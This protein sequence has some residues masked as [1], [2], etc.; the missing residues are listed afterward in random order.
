MY[1]RKWNGSEWE[2]STAK[3]WDGSNWVN[4][5]I[6]TW[7]GSEWVYPR[8]S[9][10]YGKGDTPVLKTYTK[11]YYAKWAHTYNGDNRKYTY[12]NGLLMQGYYINENMKSLFGF[13]FEEIQRDLRGATINNVGLYLTPATFMVE[14]LTARVH[15]H[16]FT[17]KPEFFDLTIMDVGSR[18]FKRDFTNKM[19]PTRIEIDPKA[20]GGLLTGDVT[21]FGLYDRNSTGKF[22]DVKYGAWY[23]IH[24]NYTYLE[25]SFTK[26][27]RG[28]E[29]EVVLDKKPDYSNY[30]PADSYKYTLPKTPTYNYTPTPTKT[31]PVVKNPVLVE[32]A[33]YFTTPKGWGLSQIVDHL[34]REGIYPGKNDA[35]WQASRAKIMAMNNFSST[36]P[37]LQIGQKVKYQ[38][39]KYK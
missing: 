32:N 11:K 29:E 15:A 26:F 38:E 36:A 23:G 12:D 33:K 14:E 31:T 6:R 25:L 5:D 35:E 28:P 24:S 7:N 10:L 37:I 16:S 17:A 3:K 34:V 20:W 39:A 8:Y 4:C 2:Y 9:D 27:V 30:L 22:P 1:I 21:G 18:K 19:I 13:D